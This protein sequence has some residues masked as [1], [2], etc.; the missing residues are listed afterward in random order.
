M[1][2]LAL[3]ATALLPASSQAAP[4]IEP[5]GLHLEYIDRS[6][7][8]GDDFYEFANGLWTKQAEIPAD[9]SYS[10]A[11]LDSNLRS[12]ERLR[13]IVAE[14]HGRADLT[15]EGVKLRDLY[16]AYMDSVRIEADGLKPIENDLAAIAA[17]KTHEDVARTMCQPT[18]RLGGRW[19]GGPALGGLFTIWIVPDDKDP[20]RYVLEFR[21]GGLGLPDREY[22]LREDKELEETR[23]AYKKYLAGTLVALGVDKA[24]A[25]RR[26]AAVYAL[27]HEI[28]AAQW[29]GEEARDVDKAYNPMTIPELKSLAPDYPWEAAITA[30]GVSLKAG[31]AD[32]IVLIREKSAFPPIAKQFAKTPIP[33]WRDYLS[34]RLV[35]AFA[36]YLPRDIQDADFAFFGR[37]LQGSAQQTDRTT[38]GV[39]L[40]DGRMG[41][42]LGKIYVAK[43]FPPE[44]K[45]KVRA[46]VDNLLIAFEEGLKSLDWMTEE[47]RAKAAEKR[48]QIV[49]KVGYPD[50]WLDYTSLAVDRD[51]L[52][53]TI[54]NANAFD[55][56]RE[57]D[58][59]DK[60]VDKTEWWM[61]PPT[62]NAY[63]NEKANEI[64]FPAGML[65]PP[66]FDLEADDAVNY[67]GIGGVIGHEISHAFDDQGSKYDGAGVLRNWWTDEDRRRFE[68]RTVE[69]V[70]Q[71]DAYEALPGL[72]VKG[73][74]TLGEN[75]GDLS[76]LTIAHKAYRI[77]LGGKEAPV[78]DGLTGD[79]R[80][81]LANAQSW[82]SM[83]RD[84]MMRQRT[85]SNPHS[86]HMFRVNGAVRNDDGWYEAF[87]EISKDDRY[88]LP[89]EQRVRL[90]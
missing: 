82:R 29:S 18:L 45:A 75:I 84:E 88:Y 79:Q 64:V 16:D 74:L 62:V 14:L 38:R 11:W 78:L 44:A 41:E 68:E 54:K 19:W 50:H 76:G 80:F 69:L 2:C 67:G 30:L 51:D 20:N 25:A 77:S 27:E 37:T 60:P 9:R 90:W 26:A 24:D 72:N 46:L 49:V 31:G 63:Y 22:Y 66:H 48:K 8:P 6:V 42:A 4:M 81:Y 15:A 89:P 32:R 59:I 5:W 28:A 1:L 39:R 7:K 43:Y 71:Y 56:R 57:V 13:A 35:H 33:V 61:S 85:L 23:E 58:R 52:V 53:G 21:Q 12:D 34:V 40:L 47:T 10:G 36:D 55:W 3:A 17:L 65:Q 86:P 87:P 83:V 70:R 73:Q